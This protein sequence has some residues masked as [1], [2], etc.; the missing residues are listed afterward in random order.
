MGPDLSTTRFYK[1]LLQPDGRWLLG[2]QRMLGSNIDVLLQRY[3]P[4]LP[5]AVPPIPA[6]AATVSFRDG[7]F[8]LTG[9]GARS[10]DWTV[11][12]I[13]GRKIPLRTIRDAQEVVL[14]PLCFPTAGS[15]VISGSGAAGTAGAV[16]VIAY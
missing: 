11:N 3:Y 15:Y 14:E 13:T 4:D 16:V 5:M 7:A 6:A 8:H 2:G 10:L 12:D 1:G 9:A